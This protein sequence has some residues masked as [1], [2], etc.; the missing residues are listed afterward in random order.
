MSKLL[1]L[2]ELALAVV[3]WKKEGAVIVH[4]HGCFDMLHI[5]HIKHLQAAKKLGN[6]LVVTVTGDAFVNKGQGRPKFHQ[7]LRAEAIAS[8]SCVDAVS[9]NFTPTAAELIRVVKPHKFVKGI[10][11]AG[12]EDEKA[13]LTEIGGH[14]I[15]VSGDV[16][17]SSTALLAGTEDPV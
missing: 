7:H 9:I 17:C 5:G 12:I 15:Y 8:L 14:M 2:E 10:E 13:A 11:F 6:I 16:I 1:T 3:A 4:A